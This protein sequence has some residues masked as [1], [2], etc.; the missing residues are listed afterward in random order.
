M[1]FTPQSLS[2]AAVVAAAIAGTGSAP[3]GSDAFVVVGG[4]GRGMTS[5]ATSLLSMHHGKSN[6]N[7]NNDTDGN[8]VEAIQNVVMGG[9]LSAAVLMSSP[10]VPA[11]GAAAPT[12]TTSQHPY[13]TTTILLSSDTSLDFSLPKYDTKM[14]GFGDGKEAILN[15]SDDMTDPGANE[16]AKQLE[17]MR[18]AE[19][20]RLQAKAA[21]KAQQ[22]ALEEESKRRAELKRAENA[23]RLKTIWN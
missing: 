16:K 10:F 3:I 20:A 17:A 19:E 11:A 15:G 6:R 4:G 21:K 9:I 14:G 23:E 7:R 2:S 8:G 12:M 5:L 18:K 1:K 13:E 22:K